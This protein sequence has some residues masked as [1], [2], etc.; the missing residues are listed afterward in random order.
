MRHSQLSNL[1]HGI[2]VSAYWSKDRWKGQVGVISKM[3]FDKSYLDQ[4]KSEH[5]H[6]VKPDTQNGKRR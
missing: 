4:L 6:H 5:F 3:G 1:A 2:V